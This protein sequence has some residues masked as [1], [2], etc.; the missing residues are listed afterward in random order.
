MKYRKFGKLDWEVSVLGFGVMRL[1]QN[2]DDMGDVDEEESIRM[3]RYA[4]DQ[5]VNYLDSAYLYHMGK[6]EPI[7]SRALEGGY[8]DN[9]PFADG[10]KVILSDTDH[11]W[12]I[13]GDVAWAWKTFLRGMNPLFMDP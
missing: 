1:P 5:G 13:G 8:R 12:G 7:I 2:S 10:K 11:L 6:S 3:I 4:I 9:P